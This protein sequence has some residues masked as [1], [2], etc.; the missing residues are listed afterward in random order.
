[1][2]Q[3]NICGLAPKHAALT[4]AAGI[5]KFDVILLQETLQKGNHNLG[6]TG[7]NRFKLPSNEEGTRGL[8]T[9]VKN[10][11]PTQ[12]ITNPINCGEGVEVL[13]VSLQLLNT[14]L[15]IYN[16]Y[17]HLQSTLELG[18][19]FATDSNIF[20]GGDFNA[21]HPILNSTQ[22]PNEDGNHIAFLLNEFEGISLLNNGRPTHIRGGRLDL[23]FSNT[24]L[25]PLINWRIHPSLT[26]DHFGITAQIKLPTIPPPPPP[27]PRWNLALA[28]WSKFRQ[29]LERWVQNYTPPDDVDILEADIVQAFHK[30]CE[31]SMPKTK[32]HKHHFKDAWYYSPEVKKLKNR[33]NRVRKL[34][35]K[36]PSDTNHG[37]LTT[38]ARDV[39]IQ[40]AEIR[41]TKWLE[42]CGKLHEHTSTKQLWLWLN[43]VAGK[44]QKANTHPNPLQ[45]AKRL[46][47]TFADRSASN[48]LPIQTQNIQNNLQDQRWT[49]INQACLEED[50]TNTP[51]TTAELKNTYKAKRDT[52]P[53]ADSITYTMIQN[54]GDAGEKIFLL[55]LNKTYISHTRPNNWNCADIQPIP[56]KEPGSYRPISLL[57]CLEK[58]A[59]KMVLERLKHKVGPLHTNLYAFRNGVGTTECIADVLSCINHKPAIIT[60]LDLEKAFELANPAAILDSL[61]RKGVKGHLLAWVKNFSTNRFARVRFQGQ[62]SQYQPLEN[63]TPQGG[64]L[65]PFL[66]NILMESFTS[67]T[68]PPGVDI[69]IYADDICLISRGLNKIPKLQRALNSIY[70]SCSQ[71]GL[72][73][74]TNKT[75]AM[76]IKTSQPGTSLTLDGQPIE[77][78]NHFTYLGIILDQKLSFQPQV[79]YL[80]QRANA[81]FSVMRK[82]TSLQQGAGSHILKTYY[83]AT[84][85]SIIDY[86]AINL[87]KLSQNQI[88]SIEVI[89]NNAMRIILGAPMWTR[90]CNLQAETHLP[91][92]KTRIQIKNCH[93]I[94]KTLLQRPHS[95]LASRIKTE[96]A[97]HPD[98]PR[99]NTYA[100]TLGDCIRECNMA[101]KMAG[102]QPDLGCPNLI[103][104][105]PWETFPAKIFYTKLPNNK[106][107]CTPLQLKTAAQASIL[108]ASQDGGITY[109]TDGTVDPPSGLTGAG[110]Y[111]EN[112]TA[113]WRTSNTCSTLQTELTAIRLTLLHSIQCEEGPITIH[114]DSKSSLQALQQ[115]HF[116]ENNQ[117]LSNIIH[118]LCL[119]RNA[120]RPVILNWMP[121]HI[122]IYGN[123]MA[124]EMAKSAIHSNTISTHIQPSLSQYKNLTKNIPHS[125]IIQ[126]LNLWVENNSPSAYWYK[127]T[128][129]LE[130]PPVDKFTPRKIAVILY[131]LRLGYKCCWEVIQPMERECSHCTA[132]PLHPLYHYLLECPATAS[133]REGLGTL[134]GSN[135]PEATINAI[136]VAQHILSNPEAHYNILQNHPPPR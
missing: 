84:T 32:H 111:S 30:A 52:A 35:R 15:I 78:V 75:K 81:R 110:V 63:G 71:I 90:I 7:Y 85:R 100:A 133:L 135:N 106:N 22:S 115:K 130:P 108:A 21:H 60:F 89:Q 118:L 59:E 129:K 64:I 128:T 10:T 61:T 121:S 57:S 8:I 97:R 39:H 5:E 36:H 104:P 43:R 9:L 94:I 99:P 87:T 68:L 112:F 82:M 96:L 25:K 119:H 62:I 88:N 19:L 116:R 49:N 122:N 117:L 103:K 12:L 34:F 42:W 44:K 65:S 107:S 76:A 33:L 37:L 50:I 18:E 134:V 102:I 132:T 91:P 127:N 14:N 1:M 136:R 105:A 13:A 38:V 17:K 66:F 16:I 24:H 98:L 58:T 92:L 41:T 69:F 70:S 67:I 6:L 73:I 124:D 74:N 86:G 2:F 95:F 20:K 28:N 114:T 113:A 31:A 101:A 26:S 120:G 56:K 23:S 27:P 53:G 77:W 51:F 79:C 29:Y 47:E 83:M 54:M 55:L 126:N 72:K 123:D 125:N 4:A 80:R 3:W 109:Y 93:T 45:E 40:L 131:R 48:Q 11:I 46:A